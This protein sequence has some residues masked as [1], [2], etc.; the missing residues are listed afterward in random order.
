MTTE[1]VGAALR[2]ALEPL[3]TAVVRRFDTVD[4]ALRD[5]ADRTERLERQLVVIRNE[6]ANVQQEL[7]NLTAD[8]G[9]LLGRARRQDQRLDDLERRVIALEQ[10]R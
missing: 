8:I 2:A 10:A 1:D 5:Q 4:R 7:A 9:D 3:E 6:L